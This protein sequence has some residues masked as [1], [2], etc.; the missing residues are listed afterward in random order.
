[1]WHLTGHLSTVMFMSNSIAEFNDVTLDY[2]TFGPD[3]GPLALCLHGFPDTRETFRFLTPHLAAQGFRV[4][5]P[6]MRGYAPSTVSKTGNYQLATL[7]NDA[8]R[9]HEVLGGDERAILIGHDWGAAAA[10]PALGAEPDR[11]RRAVTIAVPPA[12]VI[13]SIFLS[14]EQLR[15][16]WYMFFFQSPL[17]DVVVPLSNFDFIEKLWAEWSPGHEYQFDV[18]LVR[19]AL[20]DE[21][22]LKA[23]LG[24]YRAMFTSDLID[25]SLAPVQAAMFA[26][27]TVPTLYVHGRNDGCMLASKM[28]GVREFL[29]PGSQV[30]IVEDAGHFVH[31]ERP[32]Y[33]HALID[34]FIAL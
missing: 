32:A 16:S 28:D 25:T 22:N 30:E 4:V 20:G 29:A 15:A 2:L 6:A 11:W 34:S 33:V 12:A 18:D 27:P 23:A 31:L 7:A 13:G 17:A 1:M 24:Y 19:E 3:D 9:L 21:A 8:N 14:F 26:A 10:Y 5:T